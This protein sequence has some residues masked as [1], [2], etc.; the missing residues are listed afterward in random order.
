[1]YKFWGSLLLGEHSYS[2]NPMQ[3]HIEISQIV[4]LSHDAFERWLQLFTENIDA[5]FTGQK[6]EEAKLRASNIAR[7]MSFRVNPSSNL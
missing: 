6:A 2:G 4:P 1:M 3:K 5:Q 7:L